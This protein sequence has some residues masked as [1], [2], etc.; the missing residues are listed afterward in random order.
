MMAL[1]FAGVGA[2]YL[3][4]THDRMLG[5]Y[6]Q[7]RHLIIDEEPE[8]EWTPP[9]SAEEERGKVTEELAHQLEDRVGRQ[10]TDLQGLRIQVLSLADQLNKA[11][12]EVAKSN[13]A[14]E[15][16]QAEY[17]KALQRVGAVTLVSGTAGE[18]DSPLSSASP[19]SGDGSPAGATSQSGKINLNT[20][21]L[22]ELD[23]LPG[24]GLS[25]AQRII[26]YRTEHGPFK[27]VDELD[28]VNGIGQATIAK[29]KDLVGV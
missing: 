4:L 20:A 7:A 21:S 10:E 16:R 29:I 5:A 12:A 15:K 1:A 18:K 25:Y 28:G 22:S 6:V 8:R 19:V 13:D 2:W 14:L 3:P 17:L 11:V 9:S 24:I 23:S 27:N 26:D